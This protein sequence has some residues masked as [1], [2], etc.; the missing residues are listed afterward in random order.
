MPG[1]HECHIVMC[2]RGTCMKGVYMALGLYGRRVVSSKSM[3]G[4]GH[5]WWGGVCMM[6]GHVWQ[7][8][9]VKLGGIPNGG[10][11]WQGAPV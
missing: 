3:H 5:A 10:M 1:G 7:V 9:H 6:G 8:G 2:G 4:G 11:L